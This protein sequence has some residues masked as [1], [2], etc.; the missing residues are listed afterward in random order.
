MAIEIPRFAYLPLRALGFCEKPARRHKFYAPERN[1]IEYQH[2]AIDQPIQIAPLEKWLND[3]AEKWETETA[4]QSSPSAMYLQR[5]YL[6]VV[7]KG[8][9][10]PKEIVPLIIKRLSSHGGDWFFALQN[11]TGSNPAID[12]DNFDDAV[13]AWSDWEKEN[14]T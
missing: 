13:K 2:R 12:S 14:L 5:D 11:I 10:N 1:R 4:I 8:L 3:H 6:L 9:E 7:A